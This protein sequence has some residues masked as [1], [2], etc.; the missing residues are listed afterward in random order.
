MAFKSI[1]TYVILFK[2][3]W[4]NHLCYRAVECQCNE[5]VEHGTGAGKQV[6]VFCAIFYI[7]PSKLNIVNACIQN[8]FMI[9][10]SNL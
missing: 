2:T 8:Y 5:A 1:L 3:L 10:V 4:I 7:L 9:N 6:Y